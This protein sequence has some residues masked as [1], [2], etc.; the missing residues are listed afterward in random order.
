MFSMSEDSHLCHSP[1]NA[2]QEW[3]PYPAGGLRVADGRH[4][5]ANAGQEWKRH[6]VSW[7]SRRSELSQPGERRARMEAPRTRSRPF[8]VAGVTARRTPG[9]NG[10]GADR[11]PVARTSTG[12]SPANA[13]QEWKRGRA[14]Q[15]R[16]G[17]GVTAR[18]T[19]G[20]NG[21]AVDV[22]SLC[23]LAGVTARRTPGKNGSRSGGRGEPGHAHRHSPANAGQEWKPRDEPAG[24]QAGEPSQPGERRA[25]MEA[26]AASLNPARMGRHSPA[27]AGQEWKQQRSLIRPQ[28]VGDVTARRTPGKNGSGASPRRAG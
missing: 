6:L 25:R 28:G 13:G 17:L 3:K 24:R 15:P 9:K 4:S 7:P 20:K 18:R 2:G 19:P 1:A 11:I 10:S 27:N 5:P 12:H 14:G 8:A 23:G 26:A 16:D 21:S 22:V